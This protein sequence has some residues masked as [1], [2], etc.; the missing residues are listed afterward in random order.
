M[1]GG[2][3]KNTSLMALIAAAG[4]AMAGNSAQAADL[5][6]NCC[7]DLEERIA[8]L[9]AT[10]ARKGNRKVSLQIYGRVSESIVW[11]NDGGESNTYVLENNLV[12]NVVGFRGSAKINSDWSAGFNLELQIRAYRSS[13]AN[14]LSLGASNNQQIA[15]YNTQS[16]ALRY[17]FW[18]LDSRTYGRIT[19][20]RSPDPTQGIASINLAQPDGFAGMTGPGY[21]SNGFFLRR[22]GG[23]AGNAGL[24]A[25]TWG[26]AANVRNGDGP[27]SFDYSQTSS[28][29]KYTSPF[30]L[31]QTKSSGFRFDA[32]WGM[33]DMWSVALRYAETM[34]QFRIAAGVGYSQWSGADR[35]MCSIGAVGNSSVAASNPVLGGT[36]LNDAGSNTDCDSIQASASLMHV[37]TG[38]YVSGGGAQ[39]NDKNSQ[40]AFN[41]KST[42][43]GASMLGLAPRSGNDGKTGMWW[44]QAGWQAK[45]NTLGNTTFWGQ[46]VQYDLGLGVNN[47]IVQRVAANDQINSLNANAMLAG[48]QTTYWGLGVSQEI[49]AAAMTLYAGYH[50]G[51]TE[52]AL[53]AENS[54]LTVNRAK[55]RA[56]DDFHTIYT[57]ATIRF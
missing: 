54:N 30:F 10:T 24:S 35:G 49:T 48:A 1:A 25:L 22:A 3:L 4:M 47:S 51:S 33:D 23:P 50:V 56:V 41:A 37:P 31:G 52:I 12:K 43:N 42:F 15:V 2:I 53:A 16:A 13:N 57:G 39:L 9:E 7:A 28:S 55:S 27:A 36:P 46:I 44:V 18:Y 40:E 17:A 29:V 5:G 21:I 45:L 14:Q 20:G 26:A 8:E 38:L 34:G 6:G 19:V 11:W 32:A